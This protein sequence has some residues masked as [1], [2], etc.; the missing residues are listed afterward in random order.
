MQQH[1]PSQVKKYLRMLGKCYCI[2]TESDSW[3]LATTKNQYYRQYPHFG[4]CLLQSDLSFFKIIC[5]KKSKKKDI[6]TKFDV[7]FGESIIYF[8]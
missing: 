2:L 8:Y 4:N 3:P 6:E 7:L 1:S 5:R